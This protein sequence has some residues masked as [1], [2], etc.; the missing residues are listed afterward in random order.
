MSKRAHSGN[1]Q[2]LAK[3][4]VQDVPKAFFTLLEEI[5]IERQ[6]AIEAAQ[7]RA[8][9]QTAIEYVQKLYWTLKDSG[10]SIQNA[11][12]LV[13]YY[14]VTVN[15]W[16]A[17]QT[18]RDEIPNEAKHQKNSESGKKSAEIKKARKLKIQREKEE[19]DI[20]EITKELKKK[21]GFE[22]MSEEELQATARAGYDKRKETQPDMESENGKLSAAQRWGTILVTVDDE[23]HDQ[24]VQAYNQSVKKRANG[25]GEYIIH[26]KNG[27][28]D[29]VEPNIKAAPRVRK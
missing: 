22:N 11:R 2:L 21:R 20:K 6:N 17:L 29:Y 5:K 3:P 16:W 23:T 13:I 12:R 15:R 18:V 10:I 1:G 9:D 8:N 28:L 4:E 26:L 24:F 14:T 27:K 25:T 7:K 19:Q